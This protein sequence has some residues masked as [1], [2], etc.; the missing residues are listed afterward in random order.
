MRTTPL[1]LRESR[2]YASLAVATAL[3]ASAGLG[4]VTAPAVGAVAALA[5]VTAALGSVRVF[6]TCPRT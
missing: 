6:L 2:T 4:A 3:V 5:T 1:T